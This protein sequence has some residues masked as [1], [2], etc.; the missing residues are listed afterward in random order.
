LG[1]ARDL[2]SRTLALLD[3]AAKSQDGRLQA[4]LI[5]QV[6]ENI[7]LLTD[8]TK[9]P[10]VTEADTRRVMEWL[11]KE[12]DI[13]VEELMAESMK[14][15][16]VQAALLSGHHVPHTMR[17]EPVLPAPMPPPSPPAP[18]PA[19]V[20]QGEAKTSDDVYASFTGTTFQETSSDVSYSI[21]TPD[22]D[23]KPPLPGPWTLTI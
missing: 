18:V 20:P 11:S 7:R 9:A 21:P 19:A 3:E 16:E 22:P 8:L 1:D 23:L 2:R 14:I 10:P 4:V 5:G 13:P 15:A 6:R 12:H 17:P